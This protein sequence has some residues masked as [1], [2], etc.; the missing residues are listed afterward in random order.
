MST[1]SPFDVATLRRVNATRFVGV[2]TALLLSAMV[3]LPVL[4]VV[5]ATFRPESALYSSDLYW[6]PREPTLE[7]WTG[8]FE[9][10]R[11]EMINSFIIATGT[12]VLSL[13]ITVPGAYALAR[14][15]FPGKRKAFFFVVMALM[16]PGVLLIGP[17]GSAWR[18][19]GLFN[20]FPG[21][22][23]AFQAFVAPFMLWILRDFFEGLPNNLEEAA[24]VYG[25]TRASAIYYVIV[26]LSIPA[27]VAVT[28]LAFLTG[29]ND[30][31]FSN[32]LTQSSHRPAVV[33]IFE[34]ASGRGAIDWTLVLSQSF[35]IGAPP[36]AL[37]F[38]AQRYMTETFAV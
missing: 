38:L 21:L 13:V 7:N 12:A 1:R 9:D 19:L 24:R 34:S 22:W 31:L 26:P 6:I 32:L 15:D 36:V 23:I 18:D 33:S 28:F 20:T 3:V 37:Y 30:F 35:I 16:F 4:Y 10:I 27:I 14:L 8:A 29:W 25:C 5:L 11:R 17:I 2:A